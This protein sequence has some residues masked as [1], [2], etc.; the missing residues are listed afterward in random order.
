MSERSFENADNHYTHICDDKTEDNKPILSELDS[1]LNSEPTLEEL[2]VE[3]DRFEFTKTETWN[4]IAE[5]RA[6][7]LLEEPVLTGGSSSSGTTGGASE[8]S[9]TSVKARVENIEKSIGRNRQKNK[10]RLRLKPEDVLPGDPK[11]ERIGERVIRRYKGTTTPEGVWPET[12]RMT[13]HKER[14]TLI[15]E[16]K[17]F[18]GQHETSDPANEAPLEGIR[19]TDT[20]TGEGAWPGAPAAQSAAPAHAQQE[21]TRHI[22]EFCTSG[23]SEIGD[24]RYMRNGCSG[25]R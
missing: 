3:I 18:R 10:P 23:N 4:L 1:T 20:S 19:P 21:I 8:A 11:W 13:S 6:K 7:V 15:K 16:A 14:N 9:P 17:E 12:W 5:G 2:D 24:K 22:V 25:L